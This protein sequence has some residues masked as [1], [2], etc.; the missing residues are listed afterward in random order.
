MRNFFLLIGLSLFN[1]TI[2]NATTTVVGDSI[3]KTDAG[4]LKQ[5][6][7]VILNADGRLS[8]C[9]ADKKV[10]EGNFNDSKKTGPWIQYYCNG[11]TKNE[12]IFVNNQP[13]GYAKFYYSNGK[14]SEEGLWQN[15]VWIGGYKYYFENGQMAYEFNYNAQGKR[16]GPQ[17]Y[18]H[19]NGKVKIEGNWAD[20]QES[21]VLKEYY[22]DGSPKSEKT[23][24]NGRL[25]TNKVKIFIEKKAVEVKE[26]P[27]VE[28][29]KVETPKVETP[30]GFL[31]DGP[32]KTYNSKGKLA[33]DG[34]YKNSV[35]VEGKK[36]EY[37]GDKLIKT[38]IWKGGKM[39][40][41]ILEK[42]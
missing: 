14:I 20:G 28:E 4:G 42:K 1:L 10:E 15:N 23:F 33:T 22:D 39:V 16:E 11:K 41:Q 12:L 37:E 26:E 13:N 9:P 3:N 27:K 17:K 24:N 7:W 29:P 19:E 34:I 31:K 36:F 30:V 40:D 18:Y 8:D 5:G 6:H 32:N 35:M 2:L 21:G 25:D 38:S